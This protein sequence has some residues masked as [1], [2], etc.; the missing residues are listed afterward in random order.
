[1]LEPSLSLRVVIPIPNIMSL[2]II[3]NKAEAQP[4]P[5][6]RCRPSCLVMIRVRGLS[7]PAPGTL[8]LSRR[9]DG[10]IIPPLVQ[11]A[12]VTVPADAL[13]TV[14]DEEEAACG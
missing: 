12:L 14:P 13:A 5:I 1:M 11:M 9:A 4:M 8:V 3:I 10:G 7:C 6:R 2:S